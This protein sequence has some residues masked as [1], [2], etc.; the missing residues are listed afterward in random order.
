MG[1]FAG[2]TSVPPL[3]AGKKMDGYWVILRNGM[4]CELDRKWAYGPN[5]ARE[6]LTDQLLTGT[7]ELI[8]GDTIAILEGWR[9]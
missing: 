9:E 4:G 5:D 2:I 1:S 6:V 3:G 8:G 7:W